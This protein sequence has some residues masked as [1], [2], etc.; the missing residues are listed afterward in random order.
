MSSFALVLFDLDDTLLDHRGAVSRGILRHVDVSPGHLAVDDRAAA[1]TLWHALEE[2]H[3]HRYLSGELT[4]AAQRRARALDF[5]AAHGVTLADT[6]ADTWFDT[7]FERYRESWQ[8]FS[9]ALPCLKRLADTGTRVGVITNGEPDYQQVKLDHTGLGDRFEHVIASGGVGF[10]K[11]DPRIF[12]EAC[13]RF[14]VEPSEAAYVGDRLQTDAIGAARAGLT[15]VWLNRFGENVAVGAL[16]HGTPVGS[17]T[18][19]VAQAEAADAGV[20]IIGSLD[21]L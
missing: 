18:L 15:G 9:D 3:Y 11:P 8:L 2:Q 4:F 12:L 1:V 19:A 20:R 14:N 10:A 16:G 7:Y 13:R 17:S 6:D 5:A 21:E